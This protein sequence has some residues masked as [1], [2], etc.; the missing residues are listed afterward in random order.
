MFEK[1]KI[2]L[3]IQTQKNCEFCCFI[4]I[5]VLCFFLQDIHINEI[6]LNFFLVKAGKNIGKY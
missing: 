4:I 1:R 6:F 3:L 2:I 5:T